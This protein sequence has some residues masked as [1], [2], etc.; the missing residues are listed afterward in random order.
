MFCLLKKD[1]AG[2]DLMFCYR[3]LLEERC[4]Y[5]TNIMTPVKII[6]AA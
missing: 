3:A 1:L 4:I 2:C 5:S 6:E